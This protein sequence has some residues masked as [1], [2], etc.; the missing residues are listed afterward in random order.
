ME[1]LFKSFWI[2][3][4]PLALVQVA[5][6]KTMDWDDVIKKFSRNSKTLTLTA[7]RELKPTYRLIPKLLSFRGVVEIPDYLYLTSGNGLMSASSGQIVI[8]GQIVCNYSP[9]SN[10]TSHKYYYLQNCSDGSRGKDDVNV[11]SKIE[12]RL[13]NAASDKA[14]L[15]AKMKV[16]RSDEVEYGLNFPYIQATE[17]QVL[18]FNG[19]AWVAT[20]VD[21]LDIQGLEG[22][23]GAQGPAGSK[24]DA[25]VAGAQGPKGDKGDAGAAGAAGSIGPMG[26]QGPAGLRGADGTDGSKGA[27]GAPGVAGPMGPMGLTGANGSNGAAG[28]QGPAGAMGPMGPVGATGAM[29]PAGSDG[30]AGAVGPQGPAGA[31]GSMG[32]MGLSGADGAPGVAGAQGPQGPAGATGSQGATG[33]MGPMGP[34]GA[35]GLQGAMGMQGPK[36]D[37]G[38][39]GAPGV[40]GAT[41]A[42]GPQGLKGDKGDKG[43][44]GLSEIAYLRDERASGQS[45]GSCLVNIWNPRA[46]NTLGGD[47]SFISLS[48]NH[49]ILQPG[50]YFIE[51]SA[52]SYATSGHQAKLKV[53]ETN[54]DALIG[55]TA[56]SH[57]VS[58]AITHSIIS[59][60]LIVDS[61]STFEIQ[62]RCATDRPNIGLGLPV[63]FG[64]SE[65]YT[66]VKIIKKQ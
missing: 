7:G 51:I 13:N 63:N 46:L 41:G 59:G 55:S 22:E 49:F 20:D 29:G 43:D 1:R 16:I 25:G 32:P 58:S 45:G 33:A 8:D 19:D 34:R 31:T 28:S 65:V 60:E 61:A 37:D 39:N 5:N 26:P 44:R 47:S 54:A 3:S 38:L 10:V 24:G 48:N 56:F 53:L 52:P 40:A 12:V 35:D 64:T 9:R 2:L 11:M 57:P 14:T 27:D 15:R 30:T 66:Q 17:G 42:Q 21:D 6:A 4:L 36:G 50:K 23:A 62:H 18:M